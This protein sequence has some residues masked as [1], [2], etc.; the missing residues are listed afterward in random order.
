MESSKIVAL[1]I[2][3]L[4]FDDSFATLFFDQSVTQVF[5]R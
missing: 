5:S 4:T 1:Y 2:S 3:A